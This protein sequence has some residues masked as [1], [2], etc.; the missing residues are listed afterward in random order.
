[1]ELR[2]ARDLIWGIVQVALLI[3]FLVVV[4]FGIY[5]LFQARVHHRFF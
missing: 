3:G 4:S 1:M 5:H 2:D